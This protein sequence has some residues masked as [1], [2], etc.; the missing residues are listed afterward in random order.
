M[1]GLHYANANR[2][3][4][5]GISDSVIAVESDPTSIIFPTHNNTNKMRLI[6][7]QLLLLIIVANGAPILATALLETRGAWPVDGGR[8]FIDGYRVLGDSKT[9]RG[10]LFA[11]T[12]ALM[13][14]WL[15][16]IPAEI[17]VIIGI[18]VMLGDL[19]SSFIKRRLGL[20]ASS[21]ALG[22]DQ[23]PEVLF[24]LLVIQDTF[25]LSAEEILE[26]VIGFVLLEL[27]LSRLLFLLAIR[28]Q[29]Y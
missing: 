18:F 15:L 6:E 1:N 27:A 8:I 25:A 19:T 3:S 23:I 2:S 5:D 29:P 12:G 28:K 13:M 22:L 24:P 20:P 26:M 21:K 9:W 17:G 16:A 10:I 7:I 4:N 14:A 11:L